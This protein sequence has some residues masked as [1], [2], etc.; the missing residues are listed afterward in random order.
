ME[1][2][3]N[4]LNARI[5]AADARLTRAQAAAT[6][7]EPGPALQPQNNNSKKR[8]GE[9]DM[10]N[11]D[12]EEIA[13]LEDEDRREE[14]EEDESWRPDEDDQRSTTHSSRNSQDESELNGT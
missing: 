4:E 9:Q 3:D 2:G 5:A 11:L 1:G 8:G 12:G 13:D 10:D 14:E 6:G 7:V